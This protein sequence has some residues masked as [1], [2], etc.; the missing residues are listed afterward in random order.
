MLESLATILSIHSRLHRHLTIVSPVA[1]H[2]LPKPL[3]AGVRYIAEERNARDDP[4][5]AL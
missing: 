5:Q 4:M 1:W 2:E 3:P